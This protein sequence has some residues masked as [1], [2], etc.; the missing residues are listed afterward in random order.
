MADY[1]STPLVKSDFK[2]Y[3]STPYGPLEKVVPYLARRASEN[4]S[5]LKGAREERIMLRK[6]LFS[7]LF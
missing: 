3:K 1:L 4:R 5:V 6:E 2:V 7:R